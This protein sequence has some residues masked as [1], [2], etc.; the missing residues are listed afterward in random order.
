[1]KRRG[2]YTLKL[3]TLIQFLLFGLFAILL[4]ESRS[5]PLKSRLY[6]Q[7]IA[8][9]TMTLILVS[10][11][12]D[13]RGMVKNR[14]LDVVKPIFHRRFFQITF[15]IVLAT[16][17]GFLGGFILSVFCYYIVYALFQE[18]KSQLFKHLAIGFILTVIFYFSFTLFIRVPLFRGWL[19]DF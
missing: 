4:W 7:F 12:Q 14:K 2:R 5:Y 8:L 19:W 9:T 17:V 6:P 13:F 16:F 3:E 10:L 1:M 11:V 18:N 15:V